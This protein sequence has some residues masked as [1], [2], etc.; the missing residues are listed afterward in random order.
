MKKEHYLVLLII[1]FMIG[2]C[3]TDSTKVSDENTSTKSAALEDL[4][5]TLVVPWSVELNDSTQLMEI[6][7]NPDADMTNL[8]PND[9]IDAINFKYPQI[10]LEWIKQEGNKAFIKIGDASYLTSSSGT[11]GANAYMAEVTF[12]LTE[13]KGINEVNFNFTDGDHARPGTYKREDF[14]NLK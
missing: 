13:L 1:V 6:I 5:K 11:E 4:S 9:I 12:S 8:G 7:K 2:S 14:K 10:K 3:R